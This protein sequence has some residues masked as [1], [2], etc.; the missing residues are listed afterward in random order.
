MG[1]FTRTGQ[2][3][4]VGG[5]DEGGDVCGAPSAGLNVVAIEND[6]KTTI[7][8]MRIYVPTSNLGIIYNHEHLVLGCLTFHEKHDESAVVNHH[9]VICGSDYFQSPIMLGA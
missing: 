6:L 7:G 3:I 2:W 4:V 1:E 9:C 5:F 8:A